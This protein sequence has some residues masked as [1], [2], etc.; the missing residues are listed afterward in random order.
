R[1]AVLGAASFAEVAHIP[2][3]N[4]HPR[5]N[6]VA[7]YG[8]DLGRAQEMAARCSVPDA[9]D[10][11]DAVLA[12]DGIDAGTIG[13][14]GEKHYAYSV[15]SLRAGKHIFLE[16]P[17]ALDASQAAEMTHTAHEV[18]VVHQ[19]SFTFRH[20]Y[21]LSELR[22]RV[23]AGE[24]GAVRFVEIQGQWSTRPEHRVP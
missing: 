2:S 17:M 19:M 4:A 8:S 20:N 13:T 7:L 11:L 6:V 10:D 14:S 18:G 3:V 9:S 23:Q 16:K 15:E 22:R 12:R 5:A 24:I 1:L 21:A